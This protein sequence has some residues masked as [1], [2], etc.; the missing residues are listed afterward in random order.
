MQQQQVQP[1]A[2]I[3]AMQSQQAWIIL[4]HSASP[5]VQVRQQPSLVISHLHMPMV[6]LQQQTIMPFIMQ[7][8]EHMPPWSIMHR[9]CIMLQA[10]GS[11]H[12]HMIFMP[13]VH[14]SIFMV[15]RGTISMLGI[16]GAAVPPIV[17]GD[18]LGMPI[19]GIPI[20][21]RSIIIV[22]VID[23]TPSGH[24]SRPRPSVGRPP[25]MRQ[26]RLYLGRLGLQRF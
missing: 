13:P 16:I 23:L 25:A 1:Q 2:I 3:V 14:F 18:M 21:V 22:F 6:R 9:F 4:Q 17:D 12:E 26:G 5:E 15:H 8:S 10:M 19:P 11:S 7:Q 24:A 20:P